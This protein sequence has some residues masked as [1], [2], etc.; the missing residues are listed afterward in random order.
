MD[1]GGLT[2]GCFGVDGLISGHR[3]LMGSSPGG[4]EGLVF[5]L[6]AKFQRRSLRRS[7]TLSTLARKV[8][9]SWVELSVGVGLGVG[10]FVLVFCFLGRCGRSVLSFHVPPVIQGSWL[11]VPQSSAC[12]VAVVVVVKGR[13]VSLCWA[14]DYGRD[15]IDGGDSRW[16]EFECV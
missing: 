7:S 9:S 5:Q 12:I 14:R 6:R 15:A 11:Y 4:L 1:D 2:V 3:G 8:G 10:C 13:L 16:V